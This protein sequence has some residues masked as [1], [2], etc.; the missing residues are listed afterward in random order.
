MEQGY[1]YQLGD[2]QVWKKAT[3]IVNLHFVSF[4]DGGIESVNWRTLILYKCYNYT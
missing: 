3:D 1:E 2:I 4:A